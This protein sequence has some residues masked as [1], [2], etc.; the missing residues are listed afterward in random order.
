MHAHVCVSV[1]GG[2]TWAHN[3]REKWEPCGAKWESLARGRRTRSASADGEEQGEDG[4]GG[5]AAGGDAVGRVPP[6]AGYN[7]YYGK[8]GTEVL[9]LFISFTEKTLDFLIPTP[10]TNH[11]DEECV[12]RKRSNI[13][14]QTP[15]PG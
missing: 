4:C 12:K 13:K 14:P 10:Y 5:E 9:L 11:E 1:C 2:K 6:G 8:G 7:L 3:A 15:S